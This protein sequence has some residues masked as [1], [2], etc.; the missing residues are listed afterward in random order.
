MTMSPLQVIS[1]SVS[2]GLS[3]SVSGSIMR[4]LAP[5]I[6]TPTQPRRRCFQSTVPSVMMGL[7]SVSPY[8][9]VIGMPMSSKNSNTAREV[10]APPA[11]MLFSR[12]PSLS[13]I[14]ESTTLSSTLNC[15]PSKAPT[16]LPNSKAWFLLLATESAYFTRACLRGLL[17]ETPF[18]TPSYT[19]LSSA[20]TDMIEVGRATPKHSI[21]NSR[22]GTMALAEPVAVSW[23][24]SPVS[25]NTCAQGRKA[26]QVCCSKLLASRQRD[27]APCRLAHIFLCESSTPLGLP[28]VPDV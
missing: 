6:S 18:I 3:S 28:V 1:P 8:P 21:I 5:G 12:P 23:C 22:L 19:L 16:G 25:P 14:F 27:F 13:R 15:S 10:A 17:W 9:S 4:T 11:A 24:R 26:R 7:V 2:W 20:G